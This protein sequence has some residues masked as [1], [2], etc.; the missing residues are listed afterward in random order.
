MNFND[1]SL[2][3][4]HIPVSSERGSKRQHRNLIVG[5]NPSV[6]AWHLPYILRCKTQGRRFNTFLP[7]YFI[8]REGL[9]LHFSPVLRSNIGETPKRQ[10]FLRRGVKK[11]R[12]GFFDCG[13]YPLS[14]YGHSPNISSGTP[15]KATGHGRGRMQFK[16]QIL[17]LVSA[18]TFCY[19]CSLNF[20]AWKV[21]SQKIREAG[22]SS[23]QKTEIRYGVKSKVISG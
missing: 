19:L 2:V 5:L 18:L 15:R 9:H 7:H 23:A 10:P 21:L 20:I 6:T 13:I 14:P 16:K 3:G 12:I 22:I 11:D 4:T 1:K 8:E 17:L